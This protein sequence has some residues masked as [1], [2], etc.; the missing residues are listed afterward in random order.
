[1]YRKVSNSIPIAN[2]TPLL[3]LH[4]PWVYILGTLHPVLIVH[5]MY[6]DML[7]NH[8]TVQAIIDIGT[9]LINIDNVD[10]EEKEN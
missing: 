8:P 5:P 3:L 6:T 4:P 2:S 9:I 7:E 1:M 10:F